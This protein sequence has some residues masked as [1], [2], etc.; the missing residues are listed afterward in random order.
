MGAMANDPMYIHPFL[1]VSARFTGPGSHVEA[2]VSHWHYPVLWH[3]HPTPLQ[4]LVVPSDLQLKWYVFQTMLRRL[5]TWSTMEMFLCPDSIAS[6]SLHLQWIQLKLKMH[7]LEPYLYSEGSHVTYLCGMQ[8][9]GAIKAPASAWRRAITPSL[10]PRLTDAPSA[11]LA[12]S[13]L[14]PCFCP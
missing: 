5:Q 3:A 4:V 8:W 10:C 6:F 7:G 2:S 1:Q 12:L 9:N 11:P 13:S 14:T